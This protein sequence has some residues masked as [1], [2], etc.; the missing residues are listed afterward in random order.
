[1]PSKV[2]SAAI[3][4]LDAQI[5][6]IETDVSYDLRSFNVN[7]LTKALTYKIKK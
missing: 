3:V 1:M 4:G 6:E 7:H 5:I 2:F